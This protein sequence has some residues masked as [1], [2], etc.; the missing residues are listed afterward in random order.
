MNIKIKEPV[1]KIMTKNVITLDVD[2]DLSDACCLFLNNKIRHLPIVKGKKMV[3]ILS[4]NDVM[5]ISFGEVYDDKSVIDYTIYKILT[6]SQLMNENPVKVK[7]DD[8]IK[9][10]IKILVKNKFHALPIVESR[11]LA[12]MVS[13]TDLLKYL[14]T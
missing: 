11:R 14:M 6:I 2:K 5:R 12:G 13:T 7:P 9:K 10:V 8:S 3:G 1:S 4:Y